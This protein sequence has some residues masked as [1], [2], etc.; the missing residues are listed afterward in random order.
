MK[1]FRIYEKSIRIKKIFMDKET[2][3][4]VI[5]TVIAALHL[6]N[7]DYKHMG[8]YIENKLNE[9]YLP[10]WHCIIDYDMKS[11]KLQPAQYLI[12]FKCEDKDF[13]VFKTI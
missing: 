3:Q 2:Q 7:D 13:F 11:S 9:K 12:L 5:D 8:K 1:R 10:T 4:Y 6:Y